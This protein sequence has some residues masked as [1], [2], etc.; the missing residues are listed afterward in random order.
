[1]LLFSIR[2]KNSSKTITQ[3]ENI[4]V[5]LIR[6][7]YEVNISQLSY[8]VEFSLFSQPET[9]KSPSFS[10]KLSENVRPLSRPKRYKD[11]ALLPLGHA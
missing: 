5:F 10:Q 11:H 3:V 6:Y 9:E 8:V 4:L 2:T 1:M 7:R